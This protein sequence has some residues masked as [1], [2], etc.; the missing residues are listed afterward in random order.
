MA[1]DLPSNSLPV[2]PTATISAETGIP[3]Q[4]CRNRFETGESEMLPEDL[5]HE[6]LFGQP[7]DMYEKARHRSL[8]GGTTADFV[9]LPQ[10]S[11]AVLLQPLFQRL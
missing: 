4:S 7:F 10:L 5:V 1:N 2:P 9:L 11:E 8:G 3:D 6:G